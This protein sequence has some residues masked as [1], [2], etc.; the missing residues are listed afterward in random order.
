MRRPNFDARANGRNKISPTES[1]A[2]G[3]ELVVLVILT[4]IC[5]MRAPKMLSFARVVVNIMHPM[6]VVMMNQHLE[7]TVH[8]LEMLR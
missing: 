5:Q 8:L 6:Y 2:R 7:C 1:G 3:L 4:P